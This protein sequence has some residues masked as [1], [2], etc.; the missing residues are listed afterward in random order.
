M[1]DLAKDAAL[2]TQNIV[3]AVSEAQNEL[4]ILHSLEAGVREVLMWA[5]YTNTILC[6]TYSS[7]LEKIA[8]FCRGT[9]V[10]TDT[11]GGLT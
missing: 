10:H 6:L 2:W 7:V 11:R 9:K 5:H 1:A 3:N 8:S 4:P